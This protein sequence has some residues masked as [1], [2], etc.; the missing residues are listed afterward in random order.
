MQKK[1]KEMTKYMIIC[2]ESTR[3]G[4]NFSY[5]Y[6]G[7][8][9]NE[10]KY[11]KLS[12]ILINFKNNFGLN[13]LKRTKIS[14][15]N[16]KYYIEVLD[17]FFT[18]VRSGDIKVRIMFSPNSELKKDIPH[19]QNETFIRFYEVFIKDAFSIFYAREDIGLRLIFD[20]LPETKEQCQKFKQH[21]IKKINS[22]NKPMANKVYVKEEDI[23]EVDS[24]KHIILQCIDIIV[25]L[26]DF[27]LN[28]S[29][30]ELK[31]SKRA[32]SKYKVWQRIYQFIIEMN[33]N[34][35]VEETTSPIYSN[36]GWKD[37]YKHFVYHQ[38]NKT[39]KS[40]ETST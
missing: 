18:F 38:K 25:G 9:V 11:Q 27:Y 2:D 17:L 22:N 23:E 30:K 24:Q 31:E 3:K 19:S 13:E 32:Q 33:P 29:K 14:E 36:K 16:Y 15:A 37:K 26:V 21:L 20:D 40:P 35:I 28:T 10:S 7:A 34:F 12:D 1:T 6:G 39:K 5:F 4:P 8:I